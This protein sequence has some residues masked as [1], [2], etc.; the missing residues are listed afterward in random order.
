[1][2]AG[3]LQG[4]ESNIVKQYEKGATTGAL[5]LKH[6]VTPAAIYKVLKRMGKEPRPREETSRKGHTINEKAFDEPLSNEAKYWVG[7]IAA[8]GNVTS[9]KEGQSP[10]IS[11]D[12]ESTDAGHIVKFKKFMGASHNVHDKPRD[13]GR[14]STYM[15]FR[16]Q[17][18]SERLYSLGVRPRKSTEGDRIFKK[19]LD[20]C[21]CAWR[22]YSDGNGTIGITQDGQPAF[23]IIGPPSMM[24]QF[25]RFIRT[26][27]GV[28]LEL[29]GPGGSSKAVNRIKTTGSGAAAII[30]KLYGGNPS[31]VLARKHKKAQEILR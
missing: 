15:G 14:K 2:A 3:V 25:K 27:C 19:E 13:D 9:A 11:I 8:D 29:A 30:K 17:R 5:A 1:M 23:E 10:V 28:S 20:K 12:L 6:Q 22:G 16:S 4:K 18:V 21:P 26:Q 7:F 31:P 24:E